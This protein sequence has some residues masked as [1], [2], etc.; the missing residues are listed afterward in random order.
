MGQNHWVPHYLSRSSIVG[1]GL[2]VEYIGNVEWRVKATRGVGA[3]AW[4][5]EPAGVIGYFNDNSVFWAKGEPRT[6][7]YHLQEGPDD[8]SWGNEVTVRSIWD[9]IA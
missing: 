1:P 8:Y 9:N 4:L 2:E 7:T 5:T 3:Y 6:F